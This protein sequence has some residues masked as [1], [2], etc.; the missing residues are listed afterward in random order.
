MYCR[1][2]TQNGLVDTTYYKY[3]KSY[4]K[5]NPLSVP[6]EVIKKMFSKKRKAQGNG[7]LNIF[8]LSKEDDGIFGKA[9]KN[10][11][12]NID[13]K[14][15]M[16][17]VNVQDQ[18]PLVCATMAD[19]V[20]S[21]LQDFIIQY[22]TSKTKND[23]IYYKKLTTQAKQEYEKARQLY[24][25]Y[26]DANTDVILQSIK[27]KQEDLENDMQLK[28]NAYSAMLTQ[29]QAAEAKLLERTPAFTVVKSASVPLKPAGPKRMAF[30]LIMLIFSWIVTI[31]CVCHDLYSGLFSVSQK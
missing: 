20:M 6:M 14:T 22:R 8:N 9:R 30:V 17:Q 25:N 12:C 10:I 21:K 29:L 19:T 31:V 24:G 3:L 4:Q 18:D 28:Y 16:I 5:K 11:T 13:K 27:T 1:I 26:S 2:R 23:V 15:G 7:T